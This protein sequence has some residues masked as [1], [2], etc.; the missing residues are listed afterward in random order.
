[1]V[2]P[3]S[4]G[5]PN[6]RDRRRK[7]RESRR[8]AQQAQAA[9]TTPIVQQP[10]NPLGVQGEESLQAKRDRTSPSFLGRIERPESNKSTLSKIGNAISFTGDVGGA[11][12]V[13]AL[14][15]NDFLR[16]LIESSPETQ[17]KKGGVGSDKATYKIIS[18]RR[19]ELQNQG[20]SFLSSTR[21]AYKEAKENK[22][23]RRGAAFTTEVL[24]DPLTYL[25]VG[26]VSKA[27][28]AGKT[29][30]K[31]VVGTKSFKRISS[32]QKVADRIAEKTVNK[33][34][35]NKLTER[36]KTVP[37]LGPM[38]MKF[39]KVVRGQ[40]YTIDTSDSVQKAVG[41]LNVLAG[42][43]E[44]RIAG[45][46]AGIL[47]STAKLSLSRGLASRKTAGELLFDVDESGQVAVKAKQFVLDGDGKKVNITGISERIGIDDVGSKFTVGTGKN[48]K[49][50][51]VSGSTIQKPYQDIG[52]KTFVG[53]VFERAFPM[54]KEKESLDAFAG[55][56][57]KNENKG[58]LDLEASD[59][60]KLSAFDLSDNQLLYIRNVYKHLDEV[61]EEMDKA[62][63]QFG[64]LSQKFF[65]DGKVT[66]RAY[67]P[68]QLVFQGMGEAQQK[69]VIKNSDMPSNI[70]KS[71]SIFEDSE[72][73]T[74]IQDLVENGKIKVGNSIDGVLEAYT[75]GALKIIDEVAIEKEIVTEAAKKGAKLFSI[76]ADEHSRILKG[77]SD[78]AVT[79][80][81]AK[82]ILR[83]AGQTRLADELDDVGIK[84]TI[85]QLQNAQQLSFGRNYF[86][87]GADKEFLNKIAALEKTQAA[88]DF[89][90]IGTAAKIGDAMR[91]GR[92]GFDFGF[93][94]LQGIPILGLATSKLLTGSVK[95]AGNLY[96][97]W[98]TSTKQ[99]FKVLFQ[100]ESMETFMAEAA[101]KQITI[102]ENGEAVT[103]SLLQAFVDNGGALG[104]KATDIY[105][106]LDNSIFTK[107]VNETLTKGKKQITD[108][109]LR[110]FEDSYTHASD[111]LRLKG[112][113]A[114]YTTASKTDDGL[115]GLT[116]FL[117]KSTGA[118]N[119]L[120]AG[121]SPSQQQIERAFLFFSPRYTRASFSLLADVF[122]GGLRS[123]EARSSLIGTAAFGLGTY[124]AMSEALGQEPDLDPRSGSFLQV[125]IG[126]DRVGI[127]SFWRSFTK[128]A[129]KIG[130]STFTEEDIMEEGVLRQFY[131]YFAG[132]GSPVT[133]LARDMWNGTNFL[134]QEFEDKGDYLKHI[135]TQFSPFWLENLMI[136]DPY[137]NGIAGTL[138]EFGGLN[139]KPQNVWDRRKNRRDTLANDKYGRL[140]QQLNKVEKDQ[141]NKD[142]DIVEY[143]KLA[144]QISDKSNDKLYAQ[145]EI[146]Y[147]EKDNIKQTYEAE[148]AQLSSAVKNGL[149]KIQ[150][151]NSSDRWK[152]IK[153]ERRTRY[154]DFYAKLEPGGELALVEEY[155]ESLGRKYSEDEQVEDQIAEIYIETVLNNELFDTPVGFDYRAKEIAEAEFLNKY[156]TEMYEY[157]QQ[158][159]ASGK[160][161]LPYEAEYLNARKQFEFYWEASEKAVIEAEADPETAEALLSGYQQLTEGQRDDF[162]RLNPD[163][164]KY[165]SRLQKKISNVKQQLRIQNS[166]L[167]G[168]LYRWGYPGKLKHPDNLGKEDTWSTVDHINPEVYENGLRKFNFLD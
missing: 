55:R 136:G 167:D 52:D 128:A 28:K 120:E 57:L 126:D 107:S 75:R 132:R 93:S 108:Q 117:N 168:F 32:E 37:F 85:S 134:G 101:Q 158:Y 12:A 114:M 67:F 80:S 135:G 95:E 99:G 143:T 154:K 131:N 137:R 39:T 81:K 30:V 156:G 144:R 49:T 10:N 151:L 16:K 152:K 94:L 65:G 84:N 4:I 113:E 164:A 146:Y 70:K 87:S 74:Q 47:P 56:F 22:E 141:V 51:T 14:T 60:R 163:E 124:I 91:V 46:M 106:G 162:N 62:G 116:N 165:I 145:Q 64:R 110:R 115:R 100:K 109:T 139:A 1:M 79:P 63:V 45:A 88:K 34:G 122:N 86:F 119:P 21:Q 133:G 23:F 54:V 161:V 42:I 15:R 73:D 19:R 17:T 41:K 29:G 111:V 118:L 105:A 121:I 18:E 71:R 76:K 27:F 159:L 25:G 48:A 44:N 97:A 8:L 147:D 90:A 2:T 149:I 130:D 3:L 31:A 166:G 53:N 50:F 82:E 6:R 20:N 155:F 153:A 89:T 5:D 98:G 69:A 96:K 83:L 160:N 104:R 58:W 9:G 127:G 148:F 59:L 61:A 40:N 26:T 150:D 11:L 78:K 125:K 35:L 140:Y 7:E 72:F 77:L 157:A 112:F 102:I 92:T 36:L 24:F 123:N 13:Q 68:R 43:R 142:E 66:K 103:K 38:A 129:V 33:Q 138:G